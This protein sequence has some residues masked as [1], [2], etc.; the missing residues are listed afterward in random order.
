MYKRFLLAGLAVLMVLDC[1]APAF[2][3][4]GNYVE[5]VWEDE[6]AAVSV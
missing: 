4:G 1:V 5:P 6:A 2:A 3:G